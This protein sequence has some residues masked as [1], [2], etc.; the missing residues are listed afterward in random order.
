MVPLTIASASLGMYLLEGPLIIL[1]WLIPIYAF[2]ELS[3]TIFVSR[4]LPGESQA[5]GA[6]IITLARSLGGLIMMAIGIAYLLDLSTLLMIIIV[7][8]IIA[9]II[10][11]KTPKK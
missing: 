3:T 11:L 6:G 10:I 2:Y 8:C 5:S 7:L 1:F 4:T 9:Q